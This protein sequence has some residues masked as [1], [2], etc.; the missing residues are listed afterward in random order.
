VFAEVAMM[1][2][3]THMPANAANKTFFINNKFL[4]Q[5]I[6]HSGSGFTIQI[7]KKFAKSCLTRLV[8]TMPVLT[9]PILTPV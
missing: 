2:E 1:E 8:K 4:V 7:K 3:I 5:Q 9:S 6:A